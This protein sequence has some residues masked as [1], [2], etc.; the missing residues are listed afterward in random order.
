MRLQNQRLPSQVPKQKYKVVVM[1]Q[2][3]GVITAVDP[4]IPAISEGETVALA[5]QER[6]MYWTDMSD[7]FRPTPW[8]SLA[9]ALLVL[10]IDY[11]AN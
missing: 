5:R 4:T 3:D 6:G 10:Q 2:N 9:H 1:L 8:A 11:L 7:D